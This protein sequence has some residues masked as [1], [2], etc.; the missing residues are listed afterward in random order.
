VVRDPII[1]QDRVFADAHVTWID[2]EGDIG[3]AAALRNQVPSLRAV[4]GSRPSRCVS[5]FL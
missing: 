5:G 4:E 1:G 3:I 2:A